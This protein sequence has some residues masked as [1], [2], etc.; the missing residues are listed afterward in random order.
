VK[1][2]GFDFIENFTV[3]SEKGIMKHIIVL[4]YL[5]WKE[6]THYGLKDWHYFA[7]NC[8]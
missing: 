1:F 4:H 7:P 6:E 8:H 3:K 5:I 2:G